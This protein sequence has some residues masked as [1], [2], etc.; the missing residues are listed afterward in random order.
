MRGDFIKKKLDLT[1]VISVICMSSLFL[2]P[3]DILIAKQISNYAIHWMFICLMGGIGALFFG[4]E[5]IMYTCFI[6]AG[7]LSYLLMNSFNTNLKLPS[8]SNT[9]SIEVVFA[10]LS[11]STDNAAIALNSIMQEDADVVILEE[12]TPSVLNQLEQMKWSYPHRYVLPRMDP[13]GKAILSKHPVFG[14]T[15]EVTSNIPYITFGV[16]HEGWDSFYFFVVNTP[17]PITMGSF[18]ELNIFLD[19]LAMNIQKRNQKLLVAADFN[20][21]PWS[22]ELRNFKFNSGL[23]AS[24][25][26]NTDASAGSNTIDLLNAANTEIYLSNLLECFSFNVIYDTKGNPIGI[27]GKYQ[28]KKR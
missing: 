11:L 3:I 5:M 25:R 4:R 2:L 7:V 15:Q 21:V 14:Q 22:R 9:F 23:V 10:N 17:P 6:C 19:T 1:V 27:S 28:T 13:F 26:D 16:S 8:D 18:R 24:R 12:F 20:L